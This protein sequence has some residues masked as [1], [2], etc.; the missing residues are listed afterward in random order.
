MPCSILNF[1]R[2]FVGQAFSLGGRPLKRQMRGAGRGVGDLAEQTDR[3]RRGA[4]QESGIAK[5]L[6]DAAAIAERRLDPGKQHGCVPGGG[7][8][9][10]GGIGRANTNKSVDRALGKVEERRFLKT[11]RSRICDT[12][13]GQA[14]DQI[15]GVGIPI[16]KKGFTKAAVIGRKSRI[17]RGEDR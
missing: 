6:A 12:A 16:G 11:D 15:C 17:D 9:A 14:G 2:A 1:Q 3:G 5:N 4:T 7:V 13:Y 8:I 10:D